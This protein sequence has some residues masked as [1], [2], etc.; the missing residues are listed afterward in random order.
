M[1][2]ILSDPV[3]R[4]FFADHARFRSVIDRL[5]GVLRGCGGRSETRVSTAMF[6]AGISGAVIHPLVAGC[7]TTRC[8]CSC[9][10]WPIASS[11]CQPRTNPP[12]AEAT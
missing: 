9:S 1:S 2:V 11:T 10:I 8:E 5:T 6:M 12:A 3:I 4:Q 7:L